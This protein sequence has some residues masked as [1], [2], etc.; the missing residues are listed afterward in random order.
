MPLV[1][2]T[3]NIIT[4]RP[5]SCTRSEGRA[6]KRSVAQPPDRVPATPARPNTTSVPESAAGLSGTS[7]SSTG[8]M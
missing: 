2:G 1:S 4:N 3:S 5:L 7:D 6:P 8:P